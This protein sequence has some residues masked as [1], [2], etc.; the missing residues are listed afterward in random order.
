MARRCSADSRCDVAPD[1]DCGVNCRDASGSDR[2]VHEEHLPQS[3]TRPAHPQPHDRRR[4]RLRPDQ[5]P[6]FDPLLLRP[7]HRTQQDGRK[8]GSDFYSHCGRPNP[9]PTVLRGQS[10]PKRRAKEAAIR[11][12]AMRPSSPLAAPV[13]RAMGQGFAEWL[14]IKPSPRRSGTPPK[15][16]SRTTPF[17]HHSRSQKHDHVRR[18]RRAR[19]IDRARER[20]SP[21]VCVFAPRQ[22]SRDLQNHE[23][24]ARV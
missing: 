12:W 3:R 19:F 11:P 15:A 24:N 4:H 2:Q 10:A 22:R 13:P 16:R 18:H 17:R 1:A 20:R 23:A 5:R 21:S 6:T 9:R 7:G 8:N 14:T